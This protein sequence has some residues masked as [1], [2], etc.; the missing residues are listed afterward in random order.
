MSEATG[1]ATDEFRQ[2]VSRE[3]KVP[4]EF[5]CGE[6]AAEV[7]DAAQRLADWKASTAAPP[8]TAAVSAS[9][10]PTPITLGDLVGDDV[11]TAWRNGKLAPAG[12]PAPP[13]RAPRDRRG[14]PW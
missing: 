11:L 8:Q 10:P 3:T 4:L 6:T 1:K 12:I 2:A 5:L 9:T 13:P 14:M 7:W